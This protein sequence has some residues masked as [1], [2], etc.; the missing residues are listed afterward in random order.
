MSGVTALLDAPLFT[1]AAAATS[2]V[3]GRF[4]VALAGRG[5]MVDLGRETNGK[6]RR[7]SIPLLRQQ[8]DQSTQPGESSINP[9]D[10]WRRA[11]TTWH[12][13][14]GQR[15]YDADTSDAARFYQSK[16]IDVWEQG[17]I[18]LLPATSR[19]RT[20]SSSNVKVVVAGDYLYLA[21]GTDIVHTQSITGTPTWTGITGEPATAATHI[22]SDGFTIYTAHGGDG[23]Y[24]TTRGAGSTASFASGSVSGCAY[25]KGRLF[26]WLNDK[27]YNLT[28]SGPIASALLDHPNT[29]FTW[30]DVA[31]GPGFYFAAGYSGDKS[32]I[33]KIP[34]KAD[35]TSLD[36][37]TVAGELPDGEV[38]RSIQGYLG[39]LLIGTDKGVRF[40]AP[41][42]NGAVTLGGLI[43][44]VSEVRCFEGQ[45]RF[46]W[47]GWSQY[48]GDSTGLGRL[49]LS[50]FNGSRPAYASDLMVD[51]GGDVLSVVTFG[52]VRV[53]TVANAGVYAETTTV[54]DTGSIESG[55][56]AY[57]IFDNKVSMYLTANHT[58]LSGSLGAELAR[59][60]ADYAVIGE[61]NTST[62][63]TSSTF[64]TNRARA[65]HFDVKLVFNANVARTA[66]PVVGRFTL[67][68]YPSTTRSESITLPLLIGGKQTDQ[69]GQLFYRDPLDDLE[70]LES[71]EESGDS[72]IY[73]EG[74]MSFPVI[75][76]NHAWEPHHLEP[77]SRE[78][79]GTYVVAL[80]RFAQE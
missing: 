37:P 6:Y 24:A 17:V 64:I 12:L 11:A 71:L 32:L 15:N 56:I 53:F 25:V 38:V 34:V 57:G 36:T 31:D 30:V 70:F 13:G 16:G 40:G 61:T 73:Q 1:G 9:E 60:G 54:V 55:R 21:D 33:Y 7:E 65:E 49:D 69:N 63:S 45:D 48:D 22:S 20:S 77:D 39:Y 8:S 59:D 23:V 2:D 52:G 79:N 74:A 78:F 5:F 58:A 18:S 41:D 35:G 27:L 43:A 72:V 62:N 28:S 50:A 80:K 14:A 75:V 68:S 10:L 47:F 51:G 66:G 4:M 42:V 44:D 26:A 19:K 46:V 29:D 76:E 67:R 3:P